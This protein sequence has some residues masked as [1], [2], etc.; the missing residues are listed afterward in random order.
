MNQNKHNI[1]YTPNKLPVTTDE[2]IMFHQELQRSSVF[3]R[4]LA[5]EDHREQDHSSH[6]NLGHLALSRAASEIVQQPTPEAPYNKEYL[7]LLS[8]I[9]GY[10]SVLEKSM[11]NEPLTKAEKRNIIP[12]NHAIK[13]IIDTHQ[14]LTHTELHTLLHRAITLSGYQNGNDA[15]HDIASKII[16]G[17]EHELAGSAALY[18][19][20]ENP[21]VED[22]TVEDELKGVDAR[23]VFDDG[24]TI[25]I[26]FKA[27]EAAANR[28]QERHDAYREEHHITTP[29]THMI[30]WTGY[31][32][33]DFLPDKI[34]RVTPDAEARELG[35]LEYYVHERHM[36]LLDQHDHSLT[37]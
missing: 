10:M 25:T 5:E 22:T 11:H 2:T 20:S 23:L 7:Q 4:A 18:Q 21:Y 13:E 26:D 34:G 33:H 17:M 3:M 1:P 19:L 16:P 29:D 8:A 6:R 35:H 31:E 12:L 32:K 14:S 27:S 9:P 36:Q 15:V 24:T 28:A 37:K 30:Y